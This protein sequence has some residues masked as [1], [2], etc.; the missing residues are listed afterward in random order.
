[1]MLGAAEWFGSLEVTQ[2]HETRHE[3]GSH[4]G[5]GREYHL[6]GGDDLP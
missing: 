6:L 5:R 2:K 1:M 4:A 3:G